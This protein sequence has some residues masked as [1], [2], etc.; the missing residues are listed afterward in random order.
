MQLPSVWGSA[1]SKG[2]QLQYEE[3]NYLDAAMLESSHVGALVKVPAEP[4]L[5]K[6]QTV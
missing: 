4:S 5:P 3:C 1:Y 2:S 6:S